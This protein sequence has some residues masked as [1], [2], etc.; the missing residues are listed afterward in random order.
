[1]LSMR[2]FALRIVQQD[3]YGKVENFKM[4]LLSLGRYKPSTLVLRTSYGMRISPWS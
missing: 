2:L 4:D 3:G 1:M